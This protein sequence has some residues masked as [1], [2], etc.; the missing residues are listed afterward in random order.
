MAGSN[1]RTLEQVRRDI[2][3]E[4]EQLAGAAETLREEIGEATNIGAKLRSNLPV[5]A[6]GALGIGFLLAGGVG[7]TARLIF[8]RGR[9]GETKATLGRFRLVGRD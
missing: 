8:R 7:A 3:S 2:E 6:A 9:E 5:V 4:R 1:S